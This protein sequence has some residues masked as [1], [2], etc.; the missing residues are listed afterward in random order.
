MSKKLIFLFSIIII[1]I[2]LYFTDA[3]IEKEFIKSL[4]SM[5]S[6]FSTFKYKSAS[7][8]LLSNKAV[9]NGLY[10]ADSTDENMFKT[11]VELKIK[12][13]TIDGFNL[14]SYIIN[15]SITLDNIIID[16]LEL[17]FKDFDKLI[18]EKV[19]DDPDQSSVP[20]FATKNIEVNNLHFKA[21]NPNIKFNKGVDLEI[22]GS[23]Q[24]KDSYFD[25]NRHTKTRFRSNGINLNISMLKKHLPESIVN[26]SLENFK[27][28]STSS[29]LLIDKVTFKPLINKK[30]Y[31][32]YFK[33]QDIWFDL[34]LDKVKMKNANIED[35]I[36]E[37]IIQSSHVDVKFININLF[38]STKYDESKDSVD[39]PMDM[40]RN[41]SM[42]TI[43]DTIRIHN[44]KIKYEEWQGDESKIGTLNIDKF[45]VD[46]YNV[47]N[48]STTLNKNHYTGLHFSARIE[49]EISFS[50]NVNTN[51]KSKR[52]LYKAH[53]EIGRGELSILNSLI[54]E[55]SGAKVESGTITKGK[56]NFS[57]DYNYAKGEMELE[58]IDLKTSLSK[59]G[60]TVNF[61]DKMMIKSANLILRDNNPQRNVLKTGEIYY[62][63]P[64]NKGFMDLYMGAMLNGIIDI[65]TPKQLYK[66]VKKH[67]KKA[68]EAKG[69]DTS[70]D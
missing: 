4:D 32:S 51:I 59:E 44:G 7:L 55:T 1:A 23:A 3:Y 62:T 70:K 66:S 9:I 12:E 19:D 40:I 67:N 16:S 2:S 14:K 25:I 18:G 8:D 54:I 50:M 52:Y 21:K 24:F 58:Y 64:R 38:S 13:L 34:E 48:D 28:N 26:L 11:H 22:I 69:Y 35:L 60:P 31:D 36:D 42:K 17:N 57:G 53:G 33:N 47:T 41:L 10:I 63:R 45:K 37:K 30:E 15:D 49:N 46:L 39:F 6:E 65:V 68:L 56:F 20:G 29:D 61:F 5:S 43:I 27:Y